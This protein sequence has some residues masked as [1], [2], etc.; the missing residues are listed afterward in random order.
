LRN[1][2]VQPRQLRRQAQLQPNEK[3]ALFGRYSIFRFNLFDPPLLGTGMDGSPQPDNAA[4]KTQSAEWQANFGLGS[5]GGFN[6][7]G[8]LTAVN[9]GAAPNQFNSWA[10]FLLGQSPVIAK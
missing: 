1:C 6:F 4:G 8:G 2:G 9:G 7:T 10:D 5:R 3:Y